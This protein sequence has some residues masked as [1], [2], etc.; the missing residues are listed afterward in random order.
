MIEYIVEYRSEVGKVTQCPT[1]HDPDYPKG[2]YK[3]TIEPAIKKSKARTD[4]QNRALHLWFRWITMELR[5]S[6]I[7]QKLAYSKLKDGS[8]CEFNEDAV[9]A[10]F[11]L[12]CRAMF[13]IDSTSHLSKKQVDAARQAFCQ[14]FKDRLKFDLPDF[15]NSEDLNNG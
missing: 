10:M 14:F 4:N 2:G 11:Q 7:N 6:G 8:H 1:L 3:V 9:K 5:G 13:D 15:P 12:I